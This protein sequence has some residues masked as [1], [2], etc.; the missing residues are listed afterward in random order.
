MA[1]LT[2]DKLRP[3]KPVAPSVKPGQ[4][5]EDLKKA[6]AP[7]KAGR[8]DRNAYVKGGVFTPIV[9][10]KAESVTKPKAGLPD[11]AKLKKLGG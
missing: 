9:T 8:R 11:L 1:G 3:Q 10:G 2:Y 7:L 5:M 4:G 6:M